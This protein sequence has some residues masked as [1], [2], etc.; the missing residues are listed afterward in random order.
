MKKKLI[1]GGV[2]FVLVLIIVL[3][4]FFVMRNNSN[5][6][7][8]E[9]Y[10]I[11]YVFEM[12]DDSLLVAEGLEGSGPF[13]GDLDR[14]VGEAYRLNITD[15]TVILDEEGESTFF[16]KINLNDEIRYLTGN[17]VLESYPAQADAVKIEKTGLVFEIEEP[18]DPVVTMTCHESNDIRMGVIESLEDSWAELEPEIPERPSLGSTEWFT[19]YHV[20]FLG[21]DALM[22]AF[23]DGHS[24]LVSVIGFDCF[25]GEV[26]GDF[27]VLDTE[28]VYDFPLE[29]DVW[30]QLRARYG[31]FRY[32]PTTYSSVSVFI[33]GEKIEINDWTQLDAN[34]F[35]KD[36]NPE[37]KS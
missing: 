36:V 15:D 18:D 6:D 25:D 32:S 3:V 5:E 33:N 26:E 2:V 12:D 27:S 28:S 13:D 17:E 14:L 8:S 24:E 23:E 10:Y 31:D 7:G 20:Q 19:P 9:I 1:I 37:P 22:I 29:G 30:N 16:S 11:G 4:I 34:I 21:N 35:I